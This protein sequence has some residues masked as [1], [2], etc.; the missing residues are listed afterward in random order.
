MTNAL[1]EDLKWRGLIYQQTDESGI[2]NIL[3]KEQVTLYCGADPTA[4]SL[5]IGHLLPFLTL[6]RFQEHGHRPLVLIGG[7][8]GMIGDPSGKSE[9]RTLQTEAQVET[10]V[11]GIYKQMHKIFEFDTEKGAKLVNNRDWLGQISLIDFLRD[12]GKHVGV[13]YMLGK[14]SIQTRLEHGISYT[15]FTYTILQAIDFGH[16]NRTY[17][18][19]VQVGGSD[20]WGNITSGI[21]LMRRMY[22]QTEAYGLTIPLV[23]KSDGK[24]FGKTEGGAVWLDAAKT[25]PYEFYQFWIN[26]TDD[27]VI[28]F[29]KY[30]TFLEQEEIE[31]LEKSLNEAPHLREA[32]KALA[33]NVTRFIH[34]QDALDDAIRISQALFA[35]DLQS[36]SASEL[37]EG[38]KDVPQVELS[39]ETRNIVEIIVETGISSS[40][41]QAR[42]D[43]NN[44]AIYI[45]G[46][47]QQDVNYELTNEDKIENKF[48]IIRRG[49]KKY[50]MVNYK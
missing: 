16:L 23:V 6:R 26:T 12:Y 11:Q 24:K 15:E 7:G 41:R 48:T 2:E 13:N 50:F 43:V 45:N 32:Q 22:G 29:L 31:A 28:K 1:L 42:E 44:G 39:S 46:I 8:T 38:F 25:S 14:D 5:H 3:N 30:F 19:K 34:G 18:C 49:K 40:K 21:E 17:N 37:K 20:Q 27:D 47:R 33:E 36:L 10:N 4:D 35:G 9:E